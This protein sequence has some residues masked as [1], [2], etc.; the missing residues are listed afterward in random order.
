MVGALLFTDVR[1]GAR[2]TLRRATAAPR[3]GTRPRAPVRRSPPVR[4]AAASARTDRPNT[5]RPRRAARYRRPSRRSTRMAQ[6]FV[7]YVSGLV[8]TLKLIESWFR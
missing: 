1:T 8:L 5:N 2:R 3:H 6:D 7:L 4:A